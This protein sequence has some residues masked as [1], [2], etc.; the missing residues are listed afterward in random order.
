M[1]PAAQSASARPHRRTSGSAQDPSVDLYLQFCRVSDTATA[2]LTLFGL[3]L[4]D[5]LGRLPTGLDE[6]LGARL[7]VKN[8]LLVLA[9]GAWWHLSCRWGGLYDW[10]RIRQRNGGDQA[11][12]P[13]RGARR[14]A[15]GRL[16]PDQRLGLV[17]DA[18]DRV[19]LAMGTMLILLAR[20]L[21]RSTV[22]VETRSST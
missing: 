14:A 10:G 21:V 15:R 8:L 13:G 22:V 1:A 5:N 9:F 18:G 3:F 17:P 7:S 20:M 4:V 19:F 6:F 2:L 11:S 16:S 12:L